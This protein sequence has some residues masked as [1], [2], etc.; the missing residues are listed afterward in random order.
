MTMKNFQKGGVAGSAN[1]TSSFD[2][3]C[4]YFDFQGRSKTS[5]ILYDYV[6]PVPAVVRERRNM[7][8]TKTLQLY[9]IVDMEQAIDC[10][11]RGAYDQ[12]EIGRKVE[13][14]IITFPGGTNFKKVVQAGESVIREQKY[15]D[16]KQLLKSKGCA[17]TMKY[18][19]LLIT[20]IYQDSDVRGIHVE[21][22]LSG[23]LLG[24]LFEDVVINIDGRDVLYPAGTMISRGLL[25]L[26]DQMVA[27]NVRVSWVPI[28]IKQLPKYKPDAT[29]SMIMESMSS[30]LPKS[31]FLQPYDSCV[32]P[33]IRVAL[34]QGIY[35]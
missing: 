18:L 35:K 27:E 25:S 30:Y 14:K 32:N 26:A 21:T 3:I 4:A 24:T 22:I 13:T 12:I 2:V 6:S 5:K 16:P 34:N 1:L 31:A 33:I 15:L 19:A 17:S 29:E 9:E 28:G 23:M 8:G 10:I 7:D 20:S 11:N